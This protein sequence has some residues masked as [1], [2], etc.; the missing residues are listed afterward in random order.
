MQ[1]K[2]A[3]QSGVARQMAD[4]QALLGLEQAPEAIECFDISHTAGN[5]TVG[6]C[7]MPS[8]L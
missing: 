1:L 6:A 3:G 2:L 4:L 7:V 5:Q 8:R